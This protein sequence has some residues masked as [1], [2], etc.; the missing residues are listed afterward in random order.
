M[1]IDDI[2]SM[3]RLV[4]LPPPYSFRNKEK[5]IPFAENR[6]TEPKS[7]RFFARAVFMG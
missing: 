5:S 6:M 1:Y 3:F 4:S 7:G 2:E